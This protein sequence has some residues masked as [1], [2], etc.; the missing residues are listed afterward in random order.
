MGNIHR[1]MVK[2]LRGAAPPRLLGHAMLMPVRCTT[3][4]V[5]MFGDTLLGDVLLLSPLLD[6]RFILQLIVAL[7][8]RT[9]CWCMLS[10]QFVVCTI[11]CASRV[12]IMVLNS[13]ISSTGRVW[14]GC[15]GTIALCPISCSLFFTELS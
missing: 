3:P 13:L 6:P 8:Y 10:V 12:G 7:L 11:R 4:T 5:L 9:S 14:C 2:Q 1:R 15:A